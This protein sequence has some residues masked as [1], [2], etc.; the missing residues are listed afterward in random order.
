MLSFK[1]V[2]ILFLISLFFAAIVYLYKHIKLHRYEKLLSRYKEML[3]DA[4]VIRRYY[5]EAVNN[6]NDAELKENINAAELIAKRQRL[7]S[8]RKELRKLLNV[9]RDTGQ[10]RFESE[11]GRKVMVHKR[12]KFQKLWHEANVFK[13]SFNIMKKH[14]SK[15]KEELRSFSEKE[16]RAQEQWLERKD[17]VM[18]YYDGLQIEWGN[19]PPPDFSGI[20]LKCPL[21]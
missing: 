18:Q 10:G 11:I 3:N 19:F 16:E 21:K 6:R 17:M 5:F 20:R 4:R 14:H 8:I 13:L 2:F 7:N 12:L 1:T 9:I 15:L